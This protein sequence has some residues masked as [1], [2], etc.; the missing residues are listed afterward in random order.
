MT[1]ARSTP[2][3]PGEAGV[4]ASGGRLVASQAQSDRTACM[5]CNPVSAAPAFFTGVRRVR[6]SGER[7]QTPSVRLRGRRIPGKEGDVIDRDHEAESVE[8]VL[9][10]TKLA[11]E[12]GFNVR[13][14]PR[15][16]CLVNLTFG[17]TGRSWGFDHMENAEWF[18]HGWQSAIDAT[19]GG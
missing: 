15:L 14:E 4:P 19:K 16:G 2:D 7:L 18:L 10:V 6:R 1:R 5:V 8:R 3:A 17:D 11:A 12:A 9:N 13:F